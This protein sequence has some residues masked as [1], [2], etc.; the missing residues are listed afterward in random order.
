MELVKGIT[1]EQ[2]EADIKA[3]KC[4]M[5]YLCSFSLWWTHLDADVAEATEQ[6]HVFRA[7][8]DQN[9]LNDP[10]CPEE[11]KAR[12]RGLKQFHANLIKEN[13]EAFPGGAS[14]VPVSPIGAPLLQ[15]D[16]PAKFIAQSRQFANNYGK[17][18]L[19]AFIKTHHRNC[20]DHFYNKWHKYNDL[21]DQEHGNS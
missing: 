14:A 15:N 17:H 5:I 9:M 10:N 8:A 7:E 4:K 1:L 11:Q 19:K 6:G 13:P 16:D 12:L 21:I 20:E 3:G 18:G 2:V